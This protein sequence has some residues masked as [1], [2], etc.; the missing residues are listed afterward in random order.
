MITLLVSF[1]VTAPIGILPIDAHHDD[2]ETSRGSSDPKIAVNGNDVY[3]TWLESI[4]S[5]LGDVYFAKIADGKTVEETINITKG[6]SFYPRPQIQVADENVYLLWEDRK[7]S[8][9]DDQIFFAKSNDGGKSFS[10]PKTIPEDNQ[11][12]YRPFAVHQ[13]N[14]IVYIFGSNWNRDTQQNN[15]IFVTSNDFGDTFSE[16]TILFNHEQS[17]QRIQVQVHDG[18]I[19]VLSDDRNDF[20]EKG[21]I[22]LRKILPDGT[23][24][25]LVNVNG[26]KTTVT[27]P[28]FAVS[29]ENIYVSWRDRVFENGNYGITERWYQVFTKSHDGGKSFDEPITLKSDPKSIDTVSL[30]ADFVFARDDSVYILW[31]SEY[32]DGTTQSFKIYLAYSDTKGNEFTI[33][34]SPLNDKIFPHGYM[35]TELDNNDN[36]LHQMA[37]T[38]KNPPFNDAAIYFSRINLDI[39]TE[40]ADILKDVSTQIGWMPDFK[41]SGD[42]VYFVTEGNNNHNCI[43]YSYSNDGGK[44]FSNVVSISPNGTPKTCLGIEEEIAPPKKQASLGIEIEDIRCGEDRSDGYILAL[45]ERDGHPICVTSSSYDSMLERKIIDERSFETIALNAVHNYLSSHPKISANLVENSL[46]LET[47]MTRHSIPPVFIIHGS[48]ETTSPVYDDDTDPVNHKVEITLVQNNKIHLATIDDTYSLFE[49]EMQKE[50]HPRMSTIVSPT[51][52]TI[53]SPGD[54]IDNRGLI[55]LVITEVSKGGYD[56]TTHWTF[57]S[58]G[59]QGDNRDELW[60]FLP[61]QHRLSETVDENGNDA[62]DRERMPE[63]FG[64]PQPLFIFPLM[65]EGNERIEGE[66]GWHYTLPT[67]TDTLEVHYRSTDKG[68]YP[69]ENGIYDI[70]FVSMF[71]PEVE[72]RPNMEPIIN[73]TVLCPFSETISDATHAYYTHL[74]YRM[75]DKWTASYYSPESKILEEEL[76][77]HATI[78]LKVYGDKF[79]FSQKQFHLKDPRIN[80]EPAQPDL[81]HRNSEDATIGLF[82]ETLGMQ[83]NQKC[84]VFFDGRDFCNNDEYTLKFYVN[85]EKIDDISEYVISNDDRI[86]ISYELESTEDIEKQLAEVE[87]MAKYNYFSLENLMEMDVGT[88]KDGTYNEDLGFNTVEKLIMTEIRMHTEQG[89][90]ENGGNVKYTSEDLFERIGKIEAENIKMYKFGPELYEKYVLAKID[91]E[92]TI[93]EGYEKEIGLDNNTEKPFPIASVKINSETKSLDI[94]FNDSIKNNTTEIEQYKTMIGETLSEEIVWNFSFLDDKLD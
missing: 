76:H 62:I 71:K 1:A 28:Q 16:P 34:E 52:K 8:N 17:D 63:N 33:R 19:Y 21:S 83:L 50:R 64:I 23:L 81:I 41:S 7:G 57:Q 94:I 44:S 15:I 32:Y 13:V 58:I 61:D 54:R 11:S 53:L 27:Y 42:N 68:I 92:K 37:I 65:C 14:E 24:T 26:G 39:P 3:V 45:R 49:S 31:K 2:D 69:D 40:P 20:D 51:V 77:A 5:R 70:K 12:V 18:V 72:L 9:G 30:E 73:E 4:N 56:K 82:F 87:L 80:L 46:E 93:K 66:S 35:I 60:G 59:Y 47:Y 36:N 88:V 10:K 25:D 85:N 75:V 91:L 6:S 43:L 79:D 89:I 55:P 38:T 74:Q 22:Y 48:F 84:L 90:L 78:L 67:R 29:G 86:L